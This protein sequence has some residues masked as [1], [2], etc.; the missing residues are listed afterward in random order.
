ME[1]FMGS[2]R[3]NVKQLAL[4][5]EENDYLKIEKDENDARV[6]RLKLTKNY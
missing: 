4:K 6:I 1:V 5:L 2:S 3:Q